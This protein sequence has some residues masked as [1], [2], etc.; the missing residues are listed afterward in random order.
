M[1]ET[2]PHGSGIHGAPEFQTARRPQGKPAL[3]RVLIVA[4][5]AHTPA[6]SIFRP[7]SPW[8]SWPETPAS[9]SVSIAMASGQLAGRHRHMH[10]MVAAE[11]RAQRRRRQRRDH[12]NRLAAQKSHPLLQAAIRCLDDEAGAPRLQPFAPLLKAADGLPGAARE[13]EK[14]A[15]PSGKPGLQGGRADRVAP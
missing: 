6:R 9:R 4:A 11:H 10:H 1:A 5:F 15:D 2:L 8:P 3:A 14:V 7:G 13:P 12:G